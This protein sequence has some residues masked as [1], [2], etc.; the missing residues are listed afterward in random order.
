MRDTVKNLLLSLLAIVML[1]GFALAIPSPDLTPEAQENYLNE[2]PT[3]E[4]DEY[5]FLFE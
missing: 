2:G 3:T 1:C 5:A 4:D